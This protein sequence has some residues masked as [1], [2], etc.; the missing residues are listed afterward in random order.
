MLAPPHR[1]GLNG[2]KTGPL[3][4]GP[5][6]I[7]LRRFTIEHQD[8]FAAVYNQTTRVYRWTYDEAL[9]HDRENAVNME[10]DAFLQGLL[11]ERFL[12]TSQSE[13]HLETDNPKD[14]IQ[15]RTVDELTKEIEATPNIESLFWSALQGVWFGRAG[16]QLALDY[17]SV[18]GVNRMVCID[19]EPVNGDKINFQWNIGDGRPTPCVMLYSGELGRFPESEIVRTEQS[20]SLL[21]RRPEYR[22]RFVI[23]KHIQKDV[24]YWKPE[25]AGAI[26]GLGL[27]GQIYWNHYLLMEARS[28]L[29]DYFE[30]I[31]MGVTLVRY[32]LGDPASKAQAESVGQQQSRN[33]IVIMG[34]PMG[35]EHQTAGIERIEVPTSGADF[36]LNLL[37][38]QFE[39]P[40]ERVVIGQSMSSGADNDSGLGGTGRAEFAADTK[41][42]L[43]KGDAKRLA[44][45]LTT[46]FVKT[47]QYWNHRDTFPSRDNP[48]GFHI[49]FKFGV[50]P[51]DSEKDLDSA[52]TAWSM[53]ARVSEAQVLELA[54]L[55][56]PAEGERVLQKAPEGQPG[57]PEHGQGGLQQPTP[58]KLPPVNGT[59]LH[60]DGGLPPHPAGPVKP[61]AEKIAPNGDPE[62]VAQYAADAE[63]DRPISLADPEVQR[64]FL[65][66]FLSLGFGHRQAKEQ[67]AELLSEE[68]ERHE[69]MP[70]RWNSGRY[71]VVNEWPAWYDKGFKEDDHPRAT[72]GKFGKGSGTKAKEKPA[73][74]EPADERKSAFKRRVADL[75]GA[76]P[77][78]IKIK[79]TKERAFTGEPVTIKTE[80]SK[81]EQGAVGEAVLIGWLKTK[82]FKDARPMN[83]DRNNF[84]IDLIQDHEAIEAKTGIASATEGAQKWRLTFNPNKAEKEWLK[85][86]SAEDKAEFGRNKLKAIRE[87]KE[88][89]I[90]EVSKELGRKVTGKT[91]ACII[92][93]DTKTAD[94]YMLDGFHD[95][96]RWRSE[97]TQSAYQGS[98]KYGS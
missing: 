24:D 9:K 6:G 19:H 35:D 87:R 80:I 89:A 36:V 44:G 29:M 31:G 45:T 76:D 86:A 84:P 43:I 52:N 37:E 72:D 8:T 62:P 81:Q 90:K 79:S 67:L 71:V 5:D 14:P 13:W 40:I 92:N 64:K 21:L 57:G 33:T 38:K 53:G 73:K 69:R 60:G 7:P 55:S 59:P 25:L 70:Q 41:H 94:I 54:G 51:P 34:V 93:P 16:V 95:A 3:I 11:Q 30:R 91:L 88:K 15:K 32:A 18:S 39:E 78:K 4:L 68:P 98:V 96:I 75:V 26:N 50:A 97:T 17:A 22:Q 2:D 20:P 10:N 23:H 85:T 77:E 47:L 74:A 66:F 48:K 58:D 56:A 83:L 61:A 28:W 27:R 42:Q 49:R 63:P 1:N 82:G 65:A 12:P 46:D